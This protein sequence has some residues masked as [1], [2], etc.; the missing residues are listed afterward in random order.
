MSGF[1]PM[2]EDSIALDARLALIDNAK[3][4]IDLQT[5]LLADDGS[6]RLML[7]ALRDAAARGPLSRRPAPV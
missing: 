2:P 7:R 3:V 1:K 6:G 5:Y 4:S